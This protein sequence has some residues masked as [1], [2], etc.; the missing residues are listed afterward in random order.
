[1]KENFFPSVSLKKHLNRKAS[2]SDSEIMTVLLLFHFGT[3]RK[4]KCCYLCCIRGYLRRD[5]P[6]A[7]SYNRFV[8]LGQRVFFRPV[9]FSGCL[10]SVDAWA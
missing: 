10:R 7:V 4:F 2:L 3:Y 1:M 8:E 6:D 5:F 9:S